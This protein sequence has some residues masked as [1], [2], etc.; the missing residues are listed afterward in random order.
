MNIFNKV[1]FW[2]T[3]FTKFENLGLI[4]LILTLTTLVTLIATFICCL[5]KKRKGDFSSVKYLVTALYLLNLSVTAFE[6][7]NVKKSFVSVIDVIVFNVAL[8]I[9]SIVFCFL[10]SIVNTFKKEKVKIEETN[11][12]A[13]LSTVKLTCNDV[14]VE[15]LKCQPQY[16]SQLDGEVTCSDFLNVSYLKSLINLLRTRNISKSDEKDLDELELYLLNYN[17]SNF[18]N[19]EKL[20]LSLSI[21]NL[22]KKLARYDAC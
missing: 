11:C 21:S 14:S 10:I 6:F 2:L 17:S 20:N 18:L 8:L 16:E 5:I 9:I 12:N 1:L 13:K 4:S 3:E 19:D 22:M 15:K 7:I